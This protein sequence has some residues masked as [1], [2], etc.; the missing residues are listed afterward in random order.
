MATVPRLAR[1]R[2]FRVMGVSVKPGRMAFTRMPVPRSMSG[3]VRVSEI[4]PAFAAA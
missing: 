1:A 3:S 4:T 2:V